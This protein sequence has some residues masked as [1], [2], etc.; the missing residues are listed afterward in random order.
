LKIALPN[1]SIPENNPNPMQCMIFRSGNRSGALV[2]SLG[3]SEPGR[4][5]IPESVTIPANHSGAMFQI[6]AV[7]NG[8]LEG[9]IEIEITSNASGYPET[10]TD[11]TIIDDE[12]PELSLIIDVD[13]A[14]EGDTI[15]LTITRSFVSDAS[16]TVSLLAS[17]PNQFALPAT[18]IIPASEASEI[19]NV[20]A[21]DN[22]VPEL[23][24]EVIIH[25]SATGFV[26]DSDTVLIFD[27][28]MPQLSL[29]LDPSLV[30]EGG[31]T[32]ASWATVEIAEP[33]HQNLIIKISADT[34][35][36]VFFPSQ[37]SIPKGH[38]SRKFN[39][40][41]ID[42]AILDGDRDVD[43][44]AAIYL[45]SCGCDATLGTG[46]AV[47]K[48]LTILDNDGPSL[49]V[50]ATPLIVPE[51]ISNAGYLTISR[52]TL[53][54]PEITI[55]IQHNGGDEVELPASVIMPEDQNSVEVPFNTLDDEIEDGDQVVTITVSAADHSSGTC[56]LIVSDRNLPD[57]TVSAITLSADTVVLNDLVQISFYILNQGFA[58][59][60]DSVEVKIYKSKNDQLDNSSV[61]LETLYT[62]AVLYAGDS[63]QMSTDY[64]PFDAVGAYYII[65]TV[66][67]DEAF[68]ELLLVNNTSEPASLTI[69]P[70]YSATAWVDGSEFNGTTPITI[71]GK[72]ETLLGNPAPNKPADV[73]LMVDGTRRVMAI[74]S[75]NNGD[76]SMTFTP[77]NGEGGNYEVGACYP[78]QG[79]IDVHDEFTVLGAR[80]T[81][82]AYLLWD[83]NLDQTKPLSLEIRNLSST[84]LSNL[85][86]DVISS[87]PGCDVSFDNIVS[88]AGNST[89][90][91]N[92]SVTGVQVTAGK[93]YKEVKLRL[94]SAEGTV[95][96]FSAWFFCR[97]TKGNL[98]LEPASLNKAMVR[99]ETNYAEFLIVNN[100]L[101]TTGQIALLLPSNNWMSP[102][103]ES[104][105]FPSLAPGQSASIVLQL[106]PGEDLQLNNPIFG[107]IAISGSNTNSVALPFSFEP[108]S[109]AT[110]NL[111]V[112]VVNEYTYNTPEGPH[113]EGA[114][115][116]LTHPYTGL[117]VAQGLTNANGHFLIEGI[118]KGFYSLKVYAP[119]HSG[120]QNMV[121]IEKGLTTNKVVFLSFQAITYSWEVVPTL[122][123]DEYEIKLVATFETNV[124]APVVTMDFPKSIPQLG[125][126][127]VYPFLLTLTNHG[128]ITAEEVELGFPEDPEY[129]FTTNV[130]TFDLLPNSS[131]IIPVLVE[132]K[133][134]ARD[135]APLLCRD[136][137]I[138]S[139]KFECGPDK[140][141]RVVRDEI[142]YEWR[143]CVTV[144]P[145]SFAGIPKCW[146]WCWNNG[147]ILETNP[148]GPP[149]AILNGILPPF[150]NPTL[151]YQHYSRAC[152]PCIADLMN[153][154]WNC[155][156]IPNTLIEGNDNLILSGKAAGYLNQAIK[157]FN[158]LKKKMKC[159]F[160][161][162]SALF[163]FINQALG[164]PD[165]GRDLVPAEILQAYDD[166]LLVDNAFASI[167]NTT[168]EVFGHESLLDREAFKVLNDS[169]SYFLENAVP[170]GS[171]NVNELIAMLAGSDISEA[172][173]I[174]FA[175]RWNTTLEAWDLGIFSP[176]PEYPNIIDTLL[177]YDFSVSYDTALNYAN[178]RGYL[179]IIE[180][181]NAAH[182][183]A[184]SYANQK[185]SQVCARVSVQFSQ[186]LS[187]TREAFEGTLK[188]FNGHESL[189]MENIHL[190][191]EI[192]D[193]DGILR[194]NL[195]QINTQ[196]LNN[197]SGIDGGG[198]LES[199]TEGVANILFIPTRDAAPE[200]SQI[201]YFGGKLTYLDPFTGL[202]VEQA[203]YPVPLQV[204]PSPDLFLDYFMQRDILGD[205]PFTEPVEPSIP[206]ELAV[207]IENKGAGTAYGV[208]IQS[209]QPQIIDNQKG[210]LIDFKIVGSNLGGQPKNLG[211]ND[212]KFGNIEG[213]DIAV[214]QWWFTSSLLG[215]FIAYE[216]SV[217][218]MNSFGNLNLSLIS[219]VELHELIRS[220]KVYGPLD[221]GINDFLVNAIPDI[222]DVPDVLYYS[223][224]LVEPVI[225]ANSATV[226][227]PVNM[228]NLSIELTVTPSGTGWNYIKLNDPG[229]GNYAI[230]SCIRSDSQVIP[231]DNIWLT[232]VTIPDGGMPVYENKLHFIDIFD[233]AAPYTYTVTFEPENL[234]LPEVVAFGGIPAGVTDAQVLWFNVVFNKPIDPETFDHGDVTLSIQGG[235]DQIDETVEITRLNDTVFHVDISS[236][237]NANGFFVLTVQAAGIADLE[238]NYGQ[239][240][241][242]VTWTQAISTPAIT[243]FAGLPVS[244]GPPIDELEVLFNMPV[245]PATFTNNQLVLTDEDE[246]PISTEALIITSESANDNHFRITGLAGLTSTDGTYHLTFRVTEIQGETGLYG[247]LDQ[248]VSWT[249]CLVDPPLVEAGEDESICP[250]EI[251]QLNAILEDASSILWATSGSGSFS[252]DEIPNP[253]YTPSAADVASG[254]V[255][256]T[257]TAYPSHPCAPVVSDE[258]TL[259]ILPLIG[260]SVSIV[261]S[262]YYLCEGTMVTFTAIPVN[263]GSEPVYQWKLNG[264]NVGTN[265]SHFQTSA[266]A[267]GDQVQVLMSSSY[268]CP[269]PVTSTSNIISPFVIP[270]VIPTVSIIASDT[271]A[272]E[273]TIVTFTAVTENQGDFP[274]FEWFVN[275]NYT[276]FAYNVFE[277]NELEDGDEVQVFMYSDIQCVVNPAVSNVIQMTIEPD[278][279][280]RCPEIF[281]AS[282]Y[283]AE[284]PLTIG[285]PLGGDYSGPG[286]IGNMFD[287]AIAGL[288][289]HII[290]Y[291]YTNPETNYTKHCTFPLIV[292]DLPLTGL[293]QN[294]VV[295]E[296]E[297][298][299]YEA[300]ETITI[301]GSGT[302][303][304]V[305]SGASA[306]IVVSQLISV[307]DG[308]H[309][310]N[311]AHGLLR[312]EK[313]N[314]FC[315]IPA[316]LV[317]AVHDSEGLLPET[318]D[319]K[320]GSDGGDRLFFKI[321]PNPTT[322]VFILEI[323]EVIANSNI[324]IEIY[325]IAGIQIERYELTV[326]KHYEFDLTDKLPGIYII[327][328]IRNDKAG[329]GKIILR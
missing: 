154:L 318:P 248:T 184:E 142:I 232:H 84:N 326:K 328:L 97:A 259:T 315:E 290:T 70:D 225:P 147:V 161:I 41:V 167:Q 169:V 131:A 243:Y 281:V 286:V 9:D 86:I 39:I 191:L 111:L 192:K 218:H 171:S 186:T 81:N 153:A 117:V 62:T 279:T 206:A 155:T 172:E 135:E 263:G 26:S 278:T 311:G 152:D 317:A 277:T 197:I 15:Q 325:S 233:E 297:E 257:L 146:P 107:Q 33:F 53:G 201:Y 149:P 251:I 321:Y 244:P 291:T 144:H 60:P 6:L 31:G 24:E 295:D 213:S 329:V 303:F 307:K 30:S 294:I 199:L 109:L 136:M 162:S 27:D 187:M 223:N 176:T 80:H 214:G 183:L 29:T 262:A 160:E 82:K 54:G 156:P 112:D 1:P 22:D 275:G 216:A 35:G 285:L 98:R 32:L 76:F 273:G 166:F 10:S 305:E 220:V 327:R 121:Y 195:F 129:D 132:R 280:V 231:T 319:I 173:I 95:F 65:A 255:K 11:L 3:V 266:L 85:Q 208:N 237:T 128:L 261:A 274:Y 20:W 12:I 5:T 269:S 202:V 301:A 59:A 210:L 284:F 67:A 302:H 105:V 204:N 270:V 226:S 190:Q 43:I 221:D 36:Q 42:N 200:F 16:L 56:W 268:P 77:L 258:I 177:I 245:I 45:T 178:T 158:R 8:I 123:Q 267:P 298:V 174:E 94:T 194:N 47:T 118:N 101:D 264:I 114:S 260:N 122:I 78:G 314:S 189:A 310:R 25:A 93:M 130:G 271:V 38:I 134:Q 72:T 287:P 168:I 63:V 141:L 254:S 239:L 92:Y 246:T 48:T 288:G 13:E 148:F 14:I 75:D 265:S 211:L 68:N 71:N 19:F 185:S 106:T 113:L 2:V 34:A 235:P 313:G 99:G 215:H 309:F 292:N 37:V 324:I 51:N 52:N 55:N 120:Y 66:N 276:G 83:L 198:M 293:L 126:G 217:K 250:G 165:S 87:P 236:K 119:Q 124:P 100:G 229:N 188:I 304:I 170:L 69:L 18:A 4:I 209:S 203:L 88:L 133:E 212:V 49:S 252:D 179:S 40:G 296:P 289:E 219:S 151:E 64:Y 163:C 21:I 308:A 320:T 283:Q 242:Q 89:A 164:N 104:N 193:E 90:T 103:A 228:N 143:D 241:K 272:V 240:G 150:Q 138:A 137:M 312:L 175:N 44:T 196:S 157:K 140:Q 102:A 96:N 110:G 181:F 50:L 224:G 306:E 282:I 28:D 125:I 46:G 57:Y 227:G 249:T 205:D 127:Q 91:M 316:S 256:L 61:L 299:C 108:V 23:T 115:V 300:F 253:V 238:G 17:R 323:S 222:E 116:V 182:E 322:G 145:G 180:L 247:M 139:Y 230:A 207:M 58:T 79:L 234:N 73:Y 159:P 7:N 74:V